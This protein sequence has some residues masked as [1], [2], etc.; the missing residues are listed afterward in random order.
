MCVPP[1]RP[2][3]SVRERSK[4]REID[5]CR[6]KMCVCIYIYKK[7]VCVREKRERERERSKTREIDVC[8]GKMCVCVC[9]CVC[10]CRERERER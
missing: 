8:R 9:V 10:V 3:F 7:R 6:G 2:H 1:I 5:V 4:T